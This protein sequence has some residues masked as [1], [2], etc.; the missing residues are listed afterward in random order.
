MC[1][2]LPFSLP[3][4]I[5][6]TF[7][8]HISEQIPSSELISANDAVQQSWSALMRTRCYR[9]LYGQTMT[10]FL[11]LRSALIQGN[12]QNSEWSVRV[13][14]CLC[15]WWTHWGTLA[16]VR[17]RRG[18]LSSK[19]KAGQAR[20]P[21]KAAQSLSDPHLSFHT[22]VSKVTWAPTETKPVTTPLECQDSWG[23]IHLQRHNR[24]WV[25]GIIM[26]RRGK[27]VL[28]SIKCL[29]TDNLTF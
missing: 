17:M 9:S 29:H 16:L 12:T 18:L 6:T 8:R 28:R 15:V 10:Y 5:I 25:R 3:R 7:N 21:E 19:N 24:K 23:A 11:L 26:M 20:G 13:G 1:S 14:T 2:L 27:N 4:E 22:G